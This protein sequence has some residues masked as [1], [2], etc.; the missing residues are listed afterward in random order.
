MENFQQLPLFGR[1]EFSADG[2]Q[3]FLDGVQIAPGQVIITHHGDGS[4]QTLARVT[5]DNQRGWYLHFEEFLGH[6]YINRPL[7]QKSIQDIHAGLARRSGRRYVPDNE[8][9]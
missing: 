6:T 5:Y 1:L 2:S 3:L 9:I 7:T 4:E 8:A